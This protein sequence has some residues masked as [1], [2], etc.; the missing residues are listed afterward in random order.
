[1]AFK[2]SMA[3]LP[4]RGLT[5]DG[6]GF[7]PPMMRASGHILYL[8]GMVADDKITVTNDEAVAELQHAQKHWVA[9]KI[10]DAVSDRA[11][12]RAKDLGLAIGYAITEYPTW[13]DTAKAG[14]LRD[15]NNRILHYAAELDR[16]LTGLTDSDPG[17]SL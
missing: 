17:T 3:E 14:N 5:P 2:E 16:E 13:A 7:F 10:T 4:F 15:L 9:R 8:L 12:K 11:Q 1:M 6:N